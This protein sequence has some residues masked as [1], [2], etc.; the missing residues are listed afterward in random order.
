MSSCYAVQV[1]LTPGEYPKDSGVKL[2][3]HDPDKVS[4]TKT[5]C[6]NVRL[7]AIWTTDRIAIFLGGV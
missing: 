6:L 2:C 3:L 1:A 4:T 5:A 7:P